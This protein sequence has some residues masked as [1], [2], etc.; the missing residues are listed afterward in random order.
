DPDALASKADNSIRKRGC[1]LCCSANLGE[2]PAEMNIHFPGCEP[3]EKPSVWVFPKMV[4]CLACGYTE[5]TVAEAALRALERGLS[6][7]DRERRRAGTN[8]AAFVEGQ[9]S[10][11]G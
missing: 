3:L 2:F 7:R 4:I 10:G 1:R 9:F 6:K 8:E 5:L 11:K